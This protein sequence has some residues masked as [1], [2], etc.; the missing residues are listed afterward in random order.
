MAARV[1]QPLQLGPPPRFAPLDVRAPRPLRGQVR[2][3]KDEPRRRADALPHI[4][5]FAVLLGH[6]TGVI[7]ELSQCRHKSCL[8]R[9]ADACN[10][11]QVCFHCAAPI[12][13]RNDSLRKLYEFPHKSESFDFL[14]PSDPSSSY[15]LL[16]PSLRVCESDAALV[17]ILCPTGQRSSRL[18]WFWRA[19]SSKVAQITFSLEGTSCSFRVFSRGGHMSP[20]VPPI[21]FR[22]GRKAP[23]LGVFRANFGHYSLVANA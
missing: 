15:W 2:V 19:K 17:W 4:R 22:L 12:G 6:R 20:Y 3:Q 8:P 14:N 21:F 5:H 23:E 16:V 1:F 10:L 7:A 11:D 13:G 9:G 18:E